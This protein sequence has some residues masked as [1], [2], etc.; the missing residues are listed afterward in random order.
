MTDHADTP[1]L[2]DQEYE[3]VPVVDLTPHPANFNEGDI[4][5]I[6]ES[7]EA[8]GFYG[9]IVAQRSTGYVLA[10]N[11]R[12]VAAGQAGI[13]QVPVLWV[14]VDDSQALRILTVDNRSTRLG[15]DRVDDLIDVLTSLAMEDIGLAGTGFDG[16]DLD[17]LIA[18]QN[19]RDEP[20]EKPKKSH[21]VIVRTMSPT[22]Q[23]H[24]LSQLLALGLDAVIR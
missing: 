14:D 20:K 2:I 11:H 12:L 24:V 10:G 1:A 22:D 17:A 21:N 16:D 7:V 4:G 8:N 23:Q 9:A 5:V 19:G 15:H 6:H 3:L 18:E 13:E